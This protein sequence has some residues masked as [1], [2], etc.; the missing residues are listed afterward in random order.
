V[1]AYINDN[2]FDGGL[3]AVA[4]GGT[5]A[6][7]K[8]YI[9]YTQ[10]ATTYTEASSTFACA[11]AA[12][13]LGAPAAGS[14]SGRKVTFGAIASGSVTATQTAG[15]YALTRLA[16]TTLYFANNL[17]ATQAL[18]NGNTFSLAAFDC[19]LRGTT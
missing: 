10:Q 17:S 8:V 15:W 12:G 7:D 9:T 11:N 6:V 1:T 5:T 16:N 13:T 4:S 2:V 19:T 3:T 18:T 14:P